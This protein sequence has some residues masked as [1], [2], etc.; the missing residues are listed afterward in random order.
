MTTSNSTNY[1]VNATELIT[2]AFEIVGIA[3]AGEPLEPGD[4]ASALRTLNIL[5][6]ALNNAQCI[7]ESDT[8]D[9]LIL[10]LQKS[11][12]RIQ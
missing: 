6:K 2:S 5:L 10:T 7:T 12:R 11:Q 4:S 9:I 1:T 8:I 3:Q